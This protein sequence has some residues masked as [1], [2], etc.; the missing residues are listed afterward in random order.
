[1][2]GWTVLRLDKD[3]LWLMQKQISI[4]GLLNVF[5]SDSMA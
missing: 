1:M 5:E 3:D 4:D 2:T